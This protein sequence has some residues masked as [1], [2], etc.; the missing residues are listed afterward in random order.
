MERAGYWSLFIFPKS[1]GVGST[2]LG[3]CCEKLHDEAEGH[4]MPKLNLSEPEV[5]PALQFPVGTS[6]NVP[7]PRLP[8]LQTGNKTV[9]FQGGGLC[10]MMK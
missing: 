4:K 2:F 10:G 7:E 8:P 5:C 1:S 3:I 9:L 6:F